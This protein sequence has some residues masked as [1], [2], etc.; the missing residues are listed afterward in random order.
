MICVSHFKTT[1]ILFPF[2]IEKK[3]II[4]ILVQQYS[5]LFENGIK[6]VN[7]CVIGRNPIAIIQFIA[8]SLLT[9]SLYTK[10]PTIFIVVEIALYE[11]TSNALLFFNLLSNT[12]T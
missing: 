12:N 1:D 11:A 3:F 5:Q 6:N 2:F 9:R 4:F 10:T 8:E 7:N